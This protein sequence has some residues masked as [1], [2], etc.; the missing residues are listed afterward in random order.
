MNPGSLGEA[1]ERLKNPRESRSARFLSIFH[2]TF[3]RTLS[4]HYLFIMVR[5]VTLNNG[6]K[7]PSLAWG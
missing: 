7:M 2:L 5:S 4:I 1:D 6:V 3:H